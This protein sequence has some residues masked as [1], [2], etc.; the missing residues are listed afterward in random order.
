MNLPRNYFDFLMLTMLILS[1]PVGRAQ[2]SNGNLP[3]A[4]AGWELI[5]H[6]EFDQPGLPNSALWS[7]D[8]GGDGWGNREA[9]FYTSGRL[10]N[11]R[12]EQGH[13]IIEARR[14]QWQKA[15]YTSARLVSKNKGDWSAGRFEIRAQVPLGRGTWAAVWMLPT[16]WNLG[17]GAWPDNGE[18]DILEHV[19]HQP[20]LIHAST[21]SRKNQW[22]NNTQRTAIRRV[23]DA[24]TAFHLYGLEWNAEEIRISIDGEIYFTSRK[25]GGDW[26]SWP[27][28]R[29]FYLIMNLAIGG[30]W[31][32]ER[33]IDDHAFP[34]QMLVD[35]VRVYQRAAVQP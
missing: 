6:D 23:P 25:S 18:I 24:G 31:G 7:Y 11:A 33:G 16:V 20:G 32:A 35:Y 27:F 9:Q 5:W 26:T 2:A 17:N 8:V 10:E 12:V 21:H 29:N 4:P 34:Q 28:E 1:A 3:V 14:E 15:A 13:L 30:A 19:G 22:Q